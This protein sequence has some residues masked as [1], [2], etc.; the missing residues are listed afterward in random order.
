MHQVVG[1]SFLVIVLGLLIYKQ[2]G[3]QSRIERSYSARSRRQLPTL[4]D[5][6]RIGRFV[7]T[8]HHRV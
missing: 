8:D 5:T 1:Q 6:N 7:R 3:P 4:L 2:I